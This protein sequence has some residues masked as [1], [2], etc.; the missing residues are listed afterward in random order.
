MNW[1][2]LKVPANELSLEFTLPTGQSFRWRKLDDESFIGVVRDRVFHL[3][4]SD[5]NILYR[6]ENQILFPTP[7]V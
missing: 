4:Q 7:I 3:K 5:N 1:K 2:S 6:L